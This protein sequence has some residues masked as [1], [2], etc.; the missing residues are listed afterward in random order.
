MIGVFG[1]I[2][3]GSLPLPAL[4]WNLILGLHQALCKDDFLQKWDIVLLRTDRQR[5][6][7]EE[8][9]IGQLFRAVWPKI[10]K[11]SLHLLSTWTAGIYCHYSS[12]RPKL[13]RTGCLMW[14]LL[15]WQSGRILYWAKRINICRG[16]ACW[17]YEVLTAD[18]IGPHTLC[19]LLAW[20]CWC[21]D[22]SGCCLHTCSHGAIWSGQSHPAQVSRLMQ[23]ASLYGTLCWYRQVVNL[24][25]S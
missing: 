17:I 5:Y 7:E 11:K 12:E 22:R 19:I 1:V 14:K 25:L 20:A 15:P 10:Q 3:F 16:L 24:S 13:W 23:Q 9:A 2:N 8:L 6:L 4:L 18:C 21:W